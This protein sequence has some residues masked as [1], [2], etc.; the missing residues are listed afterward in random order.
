MNI[1]DVDL[2]YHDLSYNQLSRKIVKSSQ[3][4]L[5]EKLNK[6]FLINAFDMKQ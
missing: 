4:L 2:W 6:T 1:S 3:T 5:N